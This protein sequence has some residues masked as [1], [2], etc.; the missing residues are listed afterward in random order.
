[1]LVLSTAPALAA[2]HRS[3]FCD[4]TTN[5]FQPLHWTPHSNTVINKALINDTSTTDS[6]FGCRIEVIKC[7]F[8]TDWINLCMQYSEAPHCHVVSERTSKQR[9]RS[10]ALWRRRGQAT[11]R[12]ESHRQSA[13]AELHKA[14]RRLAVSRVDDLTLRWTK[15]LFIVFYK[16]RTISYIKATNG[17][18]KHRVQIFG[19]HFM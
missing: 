12:L 11:T 5:T 17:Q 16:I 19:D 13:G 4:C 8:N 6:D 1:M 3:S 9:H 10:S 14:P 2:G 18:L 15:W 7:V